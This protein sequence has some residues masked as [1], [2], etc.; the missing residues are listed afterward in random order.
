MK[1]P[2]QLQVH[3][4]NPLQYAKRF[5]LTQLISPVLQYQYQCDILS[6]QILGGFGGALEESEQST[7]TLIQTVPHGKIRSRAAGL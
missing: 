1:K 6:I 2:Y 7:S 4:K 3:K 5:N